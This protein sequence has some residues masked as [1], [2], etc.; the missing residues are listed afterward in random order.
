[1]P[2]YTTTSYTSYTYNDYTDEPWYNTV[3]DAY[4]ESRDEE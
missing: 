4:N 3:L 2:D 1:M